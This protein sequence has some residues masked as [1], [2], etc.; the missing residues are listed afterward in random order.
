MRLWTSCL[1]PCL[2]AVGASLPA[3]AQD[4]IFD[5]VPPAGQEVQMVDGYTVLRQAGNQYGA[6]LT[7]MPESAS[8]AWIPVAVLNTSGG[9]LKVGTKGVSAR[10]GKT[11]LKVW[12][13]TGLIRLAKEGSISAPSAMVE[14][15][16]TSG[17]PAVAQNDAPV[18]PSKAETIG[19]FQPGEQSQ[20][21]GTTNSRASR[22]NAQEREHDLAVAQVTAL[23]NR[24]F[25][26]QSIDA[27][28]VGRGDVR[29][30]LPP[31]RSDGQP[32]E[33]V[34]TL[35][36]GGEAMDVTYRERVAR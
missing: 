12:S 31:S 35:D 9:R 23:R 13:T 14:A 30:N 17:T 25:R 27:R 10:S 1:L 26:D 15:A 4:R 21:L 5:I 34:L 16:A 7:Y 32:A 8:T 3:L 36:F 24:L 19:A 6:V 20:T 33:F 29:I 28:E 18:A 2:L 22:S 11:E